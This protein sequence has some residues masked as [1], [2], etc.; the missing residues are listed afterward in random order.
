MVE[1]RELE[2]ETQKE[3][4]IELLKRVEATLFVAAKFLTLQELNTLTGIN[5]IMLR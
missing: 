1:G 5:P 4:E 2:V 3:N